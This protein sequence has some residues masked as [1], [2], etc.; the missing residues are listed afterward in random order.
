MK[1]EIL[2]K[3]RYYHIYNRGID[4]CDIFL[5]DNNKS[6]FLKLVD[7]YLSSQVTIFAHCL[8]D[9]HYHFVIKINE[10][11]KDVVQS[12]S[13]LFNAYAKAFNKQNNRTGSLFEKYFKRI[14][15]HDENY[16]RNLIIYVHVNPKHH[17]NLDFETYKF[18]SYQSIISNN[19]SN[20]NRK[21]IINL[22]SDFDNFVFCH[23][24]QSD[25]LTHKF[26]FE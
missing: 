10:N 20:Y 21:E 13:N 17:L 9:N 16:L 15:L 18:S 2:E 11:E 5:S 22:F 26:T 4:G 7:K 12:L 19:D 14:K 8:M 25:K 24:Q 6:Y 3:D 23:K 1:L